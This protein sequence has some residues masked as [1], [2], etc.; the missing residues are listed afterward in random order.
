MKNVHLMFYWETRLHRYFWYLYLKS[1]FILHNNNT[2]TVSCL[3]AINLYNM[4]YTLKMS[5][6]I[7]YIAQSSPTGVFLF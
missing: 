3:P 4:P 2:V 6:H 1:V 7:F 5:G